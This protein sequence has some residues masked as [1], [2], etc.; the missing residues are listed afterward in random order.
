MLS[1]TY[2]DTLIA[3][4]GLTAKGHNYLDERRKKEEG[5]LLKALNASKANA[6]EWVARSLITDGLRGFL[7]FVIG[8]LATSQIPAVKQFLLCAWFGQHH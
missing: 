7:A 8:I 4:K 6:P 2:D 3:V 5:P 1:E